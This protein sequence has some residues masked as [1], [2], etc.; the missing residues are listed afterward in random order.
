VWAFAD[1]VIVDSR[2]LLTE[3]GDGIAATQ[4]GTIKDGK[5]S[6]LYEVVAG[7]VSGRAEPLESALYKSIGTGLQDVAVASR[8]YRQAVAKGLG[9]T[10]EPCQLAKVVE[11]NCSWAQITWRGQCCEYPE[12]KS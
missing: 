2:R 1:C 10:M 6:E 3:S 11:P 9:R 8:I 4:A 5:V 12:R 7:R